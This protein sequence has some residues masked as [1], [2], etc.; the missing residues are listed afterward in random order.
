MTISAF[1][2]PYTPFR[3]FNNDG[4]PLSG[5]LL[6]SYAAGTNTPLATYQDSGMVSPNT[7]PIVLNARGEAPVFLPAN[8]AY[9]FNLTDSVG[10]QI[11]GWPI[12]NL[13]L[14]QLITLFGGV[15]TGSTNAYISCTFNSPRTNYVNGTV[16]CLG[17]FEQQYRGLDHQCEWLWGGIHRQSQWHTFGSQSDLIAGP[18]GPDHPITTVSSSSYQS[19]T[20]QAPT[21]GTFGPETAIASAATTDL[22][23]ALAHVVQITGTTT[24]TSFGTSASLSAPIYV[25]RFVYGEPHDHLQPIHNVFCRPPPRSSRL[26]GMPP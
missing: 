23:S 22:G 6:Y 5:G 26:P 11:P 7:N 16:I 2:T 9:K 24:I 20:S 14:T 15:D 1:P 13:E 8:V 3:G 4:T 12:D 10:N 17:S 19:G 25:V 18:D 21:I